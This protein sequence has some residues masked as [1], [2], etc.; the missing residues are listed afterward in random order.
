MYGTPAGMQIHSGQWQH[1]AL[2]D[3]EAIRRHKVD[4]DFEHDMHKA[5][6]LHHRLVAVAA[7]ILALTGLVLI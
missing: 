6:E 5:R 3:A 2:R 1:D 4:K 7:I